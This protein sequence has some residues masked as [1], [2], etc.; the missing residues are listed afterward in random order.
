MR[1]A[2]KQ[3]GCIVFL[4][5]I[6]ISPV[7]YLVRA[8]VLSPTKPYPF[9]KSPREIFPLLASLAKV[10]PQ[11]NLEPVAAELQLLDDIA[12]GNLTDRQLA[13]AFLIASGENDV[14]A[15]KNHLKQIDQLTSELRKATAGQ[16]LMAKGD[17]ILKT[18]HSGAMSAGYETKQSSLSVLLETKKF[19]CV[20]STVLFAL[21]ARR[22]GLKVEGLE[23]PGTSYSSGHVFA[24]VVDGEKRIDVETTNADGFNSRAKIAASGATAFGQEDITRGHKIDMKGL[25]L[26]TFN[27]RATEAGRSGQLAEAMRLRLMMLAVAPENVDAQDGFTGVFVNWIA[28]R[29]KA[30]KYEQAVIV[31]RLG[32]QLAPECRDL[33]NNLQTAFERWAR[34]EILAGRDAEALQMLIA[35]DQ[36]WPNAEYDRLQLEVYELVA[37]DK[38]D[39]SGYSDAIAVIEQGFTVAVGKT[40]EKLNDLKV[41]YI[42]RHS[43]AELEAKHYDAAAA[44]LQVATQKSPDNRE[45]LEGVEYLA[46]ESLAE[47]DESQGPAAA[48][49]WMQKL[50]QTFPQCKDLPKIA[51][52]RVHSVIRKQLDERQYTAAQQA[53]TE[54]VGLLTP[55]QVGDLHEEILH[56]QATEQIDQGN[57]EQAEAIYLGGLKLYP[58]NAE[59]ILDVERLYDKWANPAWKKRDWAAAK[60]IFD[61]G[62]TKLPDNRSLLDWQRYC[63]DRLKEASEISSK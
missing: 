39:K 13:D 41:S 36:E 37:Q 29:I 30:E 57:W 21:L 7:V 19:N 53:V 18:L 33:K 38:R 40:K 9:K 17:T 10:S 56:R 1:S 11:G 62:L 35:A 59:L 5:Y 32:M 63:A 46:A 58:K 45:L 42:R 27:N 48:I 49:A 2:A 22:L 31:G 24:I 60:L 8:E 25:L 4:L 15:R 61:R 28:D 6:C 23:F 55:D 26:S 43:Q 14:E 20:S 47:L 16:E 34:D 44:V 51:A 12:A 52:Y 3:M 54:R 50:K